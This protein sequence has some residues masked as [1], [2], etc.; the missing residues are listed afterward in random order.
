MQ[1]ILDKKRVGGLVNDTQKVDKYNYLNSCFIIIIVISVFFRDINNFSLLFADYIL[2]VFSV[3][4]SL[5]LKNIY[6][7]KWTDSKVP[8]LL[9]CLVAI[10]KIVQGLL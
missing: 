1:N 2:P 10:C 5:L 8:F 9:T 3:C 4:L 6:K 7:L